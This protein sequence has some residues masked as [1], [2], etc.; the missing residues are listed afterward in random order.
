MIMGN[1]IAKFFAVI[2]ILVGIGFFFVPTLR[3]YWNAYQN[4]KLIQEITDLN[5]E[6]ETL[7]ANSDPLDEN[8]EISEP[9]EVL[10]DELDRLYQIMQDY[11][12]TIFEEKQSGLKDPFDYQNVSIDLKEY[13]FQDN[14]IG[15]IWIP[16]MEVEMPIYLGANSDN[17]A[18]GAGLLG[19]TSMPLGGENTNM[20][21]AGHRGWYG[22][23]MFRDI[24]TL[25][26]GDKIRIT[27]PWDILYYEVC[28][29]RII[30]PEDVDKIKIQEG[31]DLLT[32]LT[33]HPLGQ[34]YQRYLV[35]AER[36]EETVKSKE[37]EI[38]EAKQTYSD[39][40]RQVEVI[41]A[42]GSRE[43]QEINPAKIQSVSGEGITSGS[44]YSNMQIWLEDYGT[45][46]I[47][48]VV[49]VIAFV[50]LTGRRRPGKYAR[51]KK[52]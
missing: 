4:R 11:N 21:L 31:R 20:V 17:M 25:Q 24:Q 29:L 19:Q 46:I 16:R 47:L 35:Y 32:L 27:T 9:T 8:Q 33:C 44:D 34:N 30:V 51:G 23:P 43:M 5:V 45:W 40:P 12:Q 26:L 41:Q 38:Q 48:A 49:L 14:V 1:K 13:G 7:S 52:K 36:V 2:M 28:G 10:V 37:E 3:E 6:R 18:K 42:D 50:L 22:I 39:V 15:T